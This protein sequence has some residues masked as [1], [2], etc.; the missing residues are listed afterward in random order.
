MCAR[1]R[2]GT[3]TYV[4]TLAAQAL[5]I[6]VDQTDQESIDAAADYVVRT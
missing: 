6:D 3:R 2:L 5:G 4:H 1:I